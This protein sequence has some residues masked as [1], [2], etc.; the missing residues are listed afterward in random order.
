MASQPLV[1]VSICRASLTAEHML[2]ESGYI[3][4][5]SPTRIRIMVYLTSIASLCPGVHMGASSLASCPRGS[6]KLIIH[7]MLIKPES[8]GDIFWI[9]SLQAKGI[10]IQEIEQNTVMLCVK[11]AA[12]L[13]KA[14]SISV[15]KLGEPTPWCYYRKIISMQL[16]I[17]CVDLVYSFCLPYLVALYVAYTFSSN[18][19]PNYCITASNTRV[20]AAS[21]QFKALVSADGT[22]SH[23]DSHSH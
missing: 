9:F 14:W 6:A 5:Q 15:S 12:E 18:L 23:L 11:Y 4:L 19:A 8:T 1:V 10:G 22:L 16:A 20:G 13:A 21:Q 3:G 17:G 2:G 7:L